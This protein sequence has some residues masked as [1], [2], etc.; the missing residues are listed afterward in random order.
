MK[1]E[2]E[3]SCSHKTNS[4]DGCDDNTSF[5]FFFF[6][7]EWEKSLAH[8]ENVLSLQNTICST[9]LLQRNIFKHLQYVY[10][11]IMYME[12]RGTLLC[13]AQTL[14]PWCIWKMYSTS[15]ASTHPWV[16][17]FFASQHCHAPKLKVS[18]SRWTVLKLGSFSIHGVSAQ[19]NYW[20][21]HWKVS[22]WPWVSVPVQNN[23]HDD[24]MWTVAMLLEL[25]LHH[26]LVVF[27]ETEAQNKRDLHHAY[28][29]PLGEFSP[30]LLQHWLFHLRLSH[31]R[32]KKLHFSK[33]I[34]W[35]FFVR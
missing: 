6:Q 33:L 13:V 24:S 30:L 25:L 8:N 14:A 15:H 3:I 11:C 28:Q 1:V 23:Q 18:G 35:P 32:S 26:L 19:T 34:W 4:L 10:L 16:S 27:G 5:F 17:D 20:D 9:S 21:W 31:H 2:Q 29:I 22:P 12:L 7:G